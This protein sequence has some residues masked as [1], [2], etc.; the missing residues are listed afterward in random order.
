MFAALVVVSGLAGCSGAQGASG[1]GVGPPASGS[2]SGSNGS[3]SPTVSAS[4]DAAARARIPEAARAHTPQGAEAFARFYLEQFN[5][6]WVQAEPAL[7]SPYGLATCKT[8][9]NFVDTAVWLRAQDLT[10]D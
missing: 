4:L 10:Y 8:C 1:P 9:A 6:S 7:I 3:G 5:D 2:A